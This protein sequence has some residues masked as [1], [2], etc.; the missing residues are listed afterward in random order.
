M[1]KTVLGT[2]HVSI[3][4]IQSFPIIIIH[5]ILEIFGVNF[6]DH[7]SV[8]VPHDVS[9]PQG[10]LTKT[11]SCGGKAVSSLNHWPIWDICSL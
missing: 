8:S 4:I 11:K 7:T 3:D 5:R 6:N 10:V 9:D 1:S 2:C